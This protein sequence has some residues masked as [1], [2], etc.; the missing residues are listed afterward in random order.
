MAGPYVRRDIW[1][2][3]PDDPIV[4]AYADAVATMQQRDPSDPTSWA[5]QAAMHGSY[6]TPP[7]NL[8]NTCEHGTWFFV[9]WHRMYVLYF[10]SIVR[11]TVIANGGPADWAL[12]Y[13][14]YTPSDGGNPS[15]PLAFRQP[16][17]PLYV[18]ERAVTPININGGDPLPDPVT[19]ITLPMTRT[20]FVVPAPYPPVLGFG[21]AMVGPIHLNGGFGALEQQPH[22]QVHNAVGGTYGWMADVNFAAQDPIFWLHHSNIDRLWASWNALGRVNPTQLQWAG[23]QF[24]FYVDATTTDALSCGGVSDLASLDYSYD[25]LATVPPVAGPEEAAVDV[26]QR[27]ELGGAS[28]ESVRLTGGRASGSAPIDARARDEVVESV[29]G[30]PTRV[31]LTLDDIEAEKNPGTVYGVYVNLPADATDEQAAEHLAGALSFFGI[32]GSGRRADGSDHV[33]S[34]SAGYDITELVRA[35][36]GRGQWDD[37]NV[38]VTFHPLGVPLAEEPAAAQ[39]LPTVTVGRISVHYA[40]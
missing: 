35:L 24:T 5:Y 13:W 37:A 28:R 22:N 39:N 4:T 14:N 9:G 20:S 15:L 6:S 16:G 3:A 33:H 17:S 1:S 36:S 11:D 26:P 21:G 23:Q 19:D 34:Y 29:G 32:E 40:G 8:W 2:L 25:R 31:F 18:W 38:E 30:A 7:L 27:S 12:P 10:E